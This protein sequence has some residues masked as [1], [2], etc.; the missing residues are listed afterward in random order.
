MTFLLFGAHVFVSQI[1][2][3][4][5]SCHHLTGEINFSLFYDQHYYNTVMCFRESNGNG[6]FLS[7]VV[8]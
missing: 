3:C 1:K 7:V 8:V 2:T 4:F 6:F 5:Q